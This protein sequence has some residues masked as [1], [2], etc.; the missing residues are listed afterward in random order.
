MESK[1]AIEAL[2][3]PASAAAP[4]GFTD[5]FTSRY[6]DTGEVRLHAV[7]RGDG[8]DRDAQPPGRPPH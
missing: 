4:A 5:A 6:I 2:P 3:G 1:H 7:T 8:L